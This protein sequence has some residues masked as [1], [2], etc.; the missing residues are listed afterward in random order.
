M[1]WRPVI[2]L[3]LLKEFIQQIS[4]KMETA[5]SVLKPIRK[6]YFTASGNLRDACF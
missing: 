5:S 2:D 4:F 3:F 1:G 6:D